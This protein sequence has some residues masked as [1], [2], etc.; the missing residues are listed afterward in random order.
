V[1][2]DQLDA[3]A[4]KRVDHL[5]QSLDHAPN[6]T[7]AR[8]HPL[9][10]RQRNSGQFGQALWSIPSSALA[11]RIWNDVINRTSCMTIYN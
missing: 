9:D 8:L 2:A 6:G 3:G 7:R 11:A 10:G 1:F 5:D 4:I